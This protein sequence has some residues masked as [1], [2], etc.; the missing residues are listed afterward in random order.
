MG[1]LHRQLE[2]LNSNIEQLHEGQV[3]ASQ[4]TRELTS[5]VR[6]L[7]QEL[8]HDRVSHRRQE[9]RFMS[10]FGGF[11]RSVT[12]LANSTSLISRRAVAAQVEAAY[13]SRNVAQGLVQITNVIDNIMGNRSATPSELGL[14][15]TE[16]TSSLSSLAVPAMDTRRRSARHSTATEADN[17]GASEATGHSSG[18]RGHKK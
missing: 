5:A 7:C 16:D 2:C 18:V 3:Q 9:R 8:H 15:D 1:G 6:E 4:D 11:C 14:G 10:M 13:S 17:R 12:R